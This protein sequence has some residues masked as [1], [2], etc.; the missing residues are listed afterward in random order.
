[1]ARAEAVS[2]SDLSA[3]TRNFHGAALI[4]AEGN[5]IPITEAMIQQACQVLEN[6]WLF[7]RTCD[8]QHHI[9]KPV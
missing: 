9:S 3:S 8:N 4:D 5:E 6:D 2:D 1:M 7:P